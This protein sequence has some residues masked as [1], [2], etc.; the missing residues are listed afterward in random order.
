[1]K[2]RRRLRRRYLLAEV[3][4][5]TLRGSLPVR[6]QCMNIHREGMG[7]YS[8]KSFRKGTRLVIAITFLDRGRTKL[9]EEIKATVRWTQKIGTNHGAGVKFEEAVTQDRFPVLTKCLAYSK[10]S[11]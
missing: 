1:M 4:F 3:K 8:K 10:M 11:K 7:L 2:E 9:T 5:K 6:A